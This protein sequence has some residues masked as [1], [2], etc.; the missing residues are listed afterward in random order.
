MYDII[1]TILIKGYIRSFDSVDEIINWLMDGLGV[2]VCGINIYRGLVG[3][4]WV[5]R[6]DGIDKMLKRR[7][8][9]GGRYMNVSKFVDWEDIIDKIELDMD[10]LPIVYLSKGD[11]LLLYTYELDEKEKLL[12]MIKEMDIRLKEVNSLA[13]RIRDMVKKL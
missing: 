6:V 4:W 13:I 9:R 8:Y 2:S 12:C 10:G 3:Y 5:A 11:V 1:M 7:V